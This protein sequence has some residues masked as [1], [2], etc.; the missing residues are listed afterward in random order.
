MSKSFI[1]K[2]VK[3]IAN[4]ISVLGRWPGL[5]EQDKLKP[6]PVFALDLSSIWCGLHPSR[7]YLAVC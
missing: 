4:E 1:L 7:Q 5:G 6:Y 3:R 2:A